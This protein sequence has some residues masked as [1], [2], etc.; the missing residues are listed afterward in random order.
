[1]DAA[2]TRELQARAPRPANDPEAVRW[3][4]RQ[5]QWER[6]LGALRGGQPAHTDRQA[7]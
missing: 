1:M 7:A 5:L 4:A 2:A 6:T 3:I